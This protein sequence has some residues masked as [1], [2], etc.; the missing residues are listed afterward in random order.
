[1]DRA[2]G[3]LIIDGDIVVRRIAPAMIEAV[4][5]AEACGSGAG[6]WVFR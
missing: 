5:Q 6:D 2:A 4:A 3:L 1:L